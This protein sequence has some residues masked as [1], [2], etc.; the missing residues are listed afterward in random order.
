[1]KPGDGPVNE[2]GFMLQN[3]GA[4]AAADSVVVK[5]TTTQAS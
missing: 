5:D 3:G 1:M 2:R 4:V